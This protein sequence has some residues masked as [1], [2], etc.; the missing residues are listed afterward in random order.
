MTKRRSLP[1][2]RTGRRL[3]FLHLLDDA[4]GRA[5]SSGAAARTNGAGWLRHL[6]LGLLGALQ[7]VDRGT[8]WSTFYLLCLSMLPI[9]GLL[10]IFAG[11]FWP[12]VHGDLPGSDE[13]YTY[14][15][16]L[17]I[18]LVHYVHDALLFTDHDAIVESEIVNAPQPA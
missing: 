18:L 3:G 2:R 16:I 9:S 14:M 4:W 10:I 1:G 17:S 8:G 12:Q 7:K 5:R 15:G 13:A 6:W 11:T